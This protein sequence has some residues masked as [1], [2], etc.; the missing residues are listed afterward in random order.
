MNTL[1]RR[2]REKKNNLLVQGMH[3]LACCCQKR[4]SVGA[5]GRNSLWFEQLFLYAQ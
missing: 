2:E 4:G 5:S 1:A 3:A